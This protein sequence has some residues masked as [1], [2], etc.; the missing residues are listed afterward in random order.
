MVEKI[1]Y[2]KIKDSRESHPR[3]VSQNMSRDADLH[4]ILATY[5]RYGVY[6]KHKIVRLD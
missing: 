2:I 5:K 1:V 3:W 4:N 6:V